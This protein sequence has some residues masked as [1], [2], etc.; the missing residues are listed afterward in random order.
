MP[1]LIPPNDILI[2]LPPKARQAYEDLEN[3]FI[4]N[5]RGSTIVA[6]NI[7]V[8]GGKCRQIC[9]GAIY[10]TSPDDSD[11]DGRSYKLLH[12]EKIRAL[13]DLIGELQG[14]PALV[15]YE[16]D[17]DKRRI[18]ESLGKHI[19]VIGGGTSP[20]QADDII[21]RFNAGKIP[22]LL[23]HPASM[24]HGLNLQE[25]CHHIIWFGITWNLEY[26]QQAIARIYR[27]GQ[28][29]TVFVHRILARNTIE[30]R[31]VQALGTKKDLQETLFGDLQW[32]S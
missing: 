9:N 8:A 7:A 19:A 14:S 26:Y 1:R 15:M 16:F 10:D 21:R 18:L 23:G 22:I 12:E 27:Q 24:A 25:A 30:Q 13:E 5:V 4:T 31:V 3:E 6:A 32:H 20:R 29:E 28:K 2:D 11:G 17:S